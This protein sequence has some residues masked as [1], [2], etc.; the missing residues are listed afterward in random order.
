MCLSTFVIL[1]LLTRLLLQ[2]VLCRG[3]QRVERKITRYE[4]IQVSY[5]LPLC[6]HR[7]SL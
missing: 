6:Y 2:R 3:E 7:V 5:Q 1:S 4:I